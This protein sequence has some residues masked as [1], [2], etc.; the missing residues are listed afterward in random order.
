MW[1]HY[2]LNIHMVELKSSNVYVTGGISISIALENKER[3]KNGLIRWT[4]LV[5]EAT[6]GRLQ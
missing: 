5:R 2:S 1:D 6:T 4:Q 3:F